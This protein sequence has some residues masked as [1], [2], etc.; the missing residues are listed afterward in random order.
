MLIET[1]DTNLLLNQLAVMEG[2]YAKALTILRNTK[3]VLETELHTDPKND[4][5]KA[6]LLYRDVVA[7]LEAK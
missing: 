5:C 6:C 3:Y 1:H 4:R 7:A 2:K